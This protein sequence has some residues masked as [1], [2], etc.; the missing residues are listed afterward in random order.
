MKL[1]SGTLRGRLL[2]QV[3]K[4]IIIKGKSKV[5]AEIKIQ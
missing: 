1:F 5:V 4:I 3:D 2:G